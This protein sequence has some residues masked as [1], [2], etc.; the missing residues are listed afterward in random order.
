MPKDLA[1]TIRLAG[2]LRREYIHE[3][4]VEVYALLM[5]RR[6]KGVIGRPQWVSDQVDELNKEGRGMD[7]VKLP[8]GYLL[9]DEMTMKDV[10]RIDAEIL[11]SEGIDPEWPGFGE[12]QE[13]AE[14]DSD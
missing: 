4:V 14:P 11:A 3:V 1:D 6:R 9:P 2:Y 13:D 10:L 8:P 5:V 7:P 12:R